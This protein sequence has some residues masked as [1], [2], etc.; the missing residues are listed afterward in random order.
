MIFKYTQSFENVP[1]NYVENVPVDVDGT[2]INVVP[3]HPNGELKACR[4]GQP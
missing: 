2:V 3:E 4:G 1:V